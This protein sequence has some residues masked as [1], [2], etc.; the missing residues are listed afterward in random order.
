MVAA[1][2]HFR[3]APNQAVVW[4]LISAINVTGALLWNGSPYGSPE[5]SPDESVTASHTATKRGITLYKIKKCSNKLLS[6][7]QS[8]FLD[9]IGGNQSLLGIC[10]TA[11]S[12]ST[13]L[14]RR[15]RP[16]FNVR[17]L[18]GSTAELEA[19][20]AI[21]STPLQPM[22][23]LSDDKLRRSSSRRQQDVICHKPGG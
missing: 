13:K 11:M 22:G 8:T 9:C 15:R 21:P 3:Q 18:A 7:T 16:P 12:R 1:F 20:T 19:S 6:L 4:F 10:I 17:V 5:G 2:V 23:P 14:S